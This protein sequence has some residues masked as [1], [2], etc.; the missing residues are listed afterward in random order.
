MDIWQ[1]DK[2]VLFVIL[3]IPGFIAIKVYDLLVPS[4]RRDFSK[5]LFEVIGYSCLNFAAL[6]WLI[7]L[8]HSG[9]FHVRHKAWYF[10]FLFFII[11]I[12]PVL[13]PIFLLKLCSWRP[14]A[15]YIIHPIK[16][17][18]SDE[19]VDL[20]Y[21]DPPFKSGKNYN[22]IFKPELGEFKGATAQTHTFEDTWQWGQ[23]AEKEYQGLITG[24]ITRERPNQKVID[25]IKSM[26][27]YLSECSIMA[28]LCMMAPRLL[29]M[30]RVLKE[31]G[32]IY[33]HCDPTASHY[34]KLLMDAVFETN[35]FQNEIVWWYLWGGRSK[36]R[37]S[38]KHDILFFYSKSDSFTFNYLEVLD[39]HKLMSESTR[40]RIQYEG[41]LITDE[42][43]S[44]REFGREKVLPSDTWYVAT[45]N[46]QAKERLGYPTQKPEA[47]LE[48]II[49]AS[50]NEGDLVL[51][52]F[53]GC[54]TAIAVAERLKRNWIGIDI[55]YLAIDVIKKRFESNAIKEGI[56]FEVDGE[57]TDVYSAEKLAKKDPFQFQLWCISKLDA[58]PSQTKSAMDTKPLDEELRKWELHAYLDVM[59]YSD[60]L[61]EWTGFDLSI[62]EV[63]YHELLHACGDDNN[64]RKGRIVDG[65]IRHNIIGVTSVKECLK[66]QTVNNIEA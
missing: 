23:E 59:G 61:L 41:A 4:E 40:K 12:V 18:I 22:I 42:S 32:S 53:C 24:N 50:S 39:E 9:S 8:I 30:R 16:K 56:D 29:E 46:A 51:D 60:G 28:Y 58:T 10:I 33:L 47:L 25:L 49:K 27:G 11:F 38:R 17:H 62:E 52:P 48:R 7:I 57:P 66:R 2:I 36:A 63:T 13:W 54:G 44:E 45:I 21:L 37:W 35:N 5:S 64:W 34:L 19:S 31:T 14:I 6:S 43:L 15:K 20:I 1:I 55:T 65:V 26:R 3:F